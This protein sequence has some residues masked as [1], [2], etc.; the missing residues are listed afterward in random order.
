[1]LFNKSRKGG[2]PPQKEPVRGARQGPSIVA[3]DLVIEGNLITGGELQIDGTVNGNVQARGVVVD[4]QGVVH[5]EVAAEEVFVRG[6]V[7]GPIRGVNVT[8]V[9]GARVEGDVSNH[10]IAIENGAI[11]E[12]RIHN[13][14]QSS[15]YLGDYGGEQP[16][17]LQATSDASDVDDDSSIKLTAPLRVDAAE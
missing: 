14:S 3:G 15:E 10:T 1:M 12:G 8:I 11:V 6:R 5:G 7:I 13:A 4:V 17:Y 16:D 9:A 2:Q